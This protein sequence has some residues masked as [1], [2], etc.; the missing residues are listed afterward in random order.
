VKRIILLITTFVSIV[1]LSCAG[2]ID[3]QDFYGTYTFDKVIYLSPLSSSTIDASNKAMAGTKYVIEADLFK[4][5]FKDNPV[6]I[7]SPNYV[8]E[9]VKF[10]SSTLFDYHT[11]LGNDV[12]YQYNINNKDGSKAHWRLYASSNSLWVASYADNTADGSEIIMNITK[13]TK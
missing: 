6:E 3:K 5:D 13:M 8:K 4:I 9:N 11:V 2:N 7:S 1:F 12:K 10:D